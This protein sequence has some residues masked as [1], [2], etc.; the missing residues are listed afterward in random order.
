MAE[1]DSNLPMLDLTALDSQPNLPSQQSG[2]IPTDNSYLGPYEDLKKFDKLN[3]S[4]EEEEEGNL[5]G[6]N[7]KSM[8]I[9]DSLHDPERRLVLSNIKQFQDDTIMTN[10]PQDML[11]G[12]I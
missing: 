5:D 7:Q 3:F 6:K 2:A 12:P 4:H 9:Y 8:E 10:D 1:Q 11:L